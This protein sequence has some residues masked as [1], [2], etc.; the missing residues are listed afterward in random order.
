[1]PHKLDQRV[2]MLV[3][4]EDA[5]LKRQ[6]QSSVFEPYFR[7]RANSWTLNAEDQWVRSSEKG[8]DVHKAL[9]D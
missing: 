7:D 8:Y 6:L 5:A 9:F 4:I 1:M 3:P 2:E